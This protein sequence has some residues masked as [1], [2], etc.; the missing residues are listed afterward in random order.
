MRGMERTGA[1]KNRGMCPGRKGDWDNFCRR[2]GP[3][4]DEIGQL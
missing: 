3:E 1:Q 2:I 4:V